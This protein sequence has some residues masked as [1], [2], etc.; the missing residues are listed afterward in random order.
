MGGGIWSG[1]SRPEWANEDLVLKV[2]AGPQ[3]ETHSGPAHDG[4]DVQRGG[5][6]GSDQNGVRP[7]MVDL[8]LGQFRLWSELGR[9]NTRSGAPWIWLRRLH[10]RRVQNVVKR[11]TPHLQGGS[12]VSSGWGDPGGRKGLDT[13]NQEAQGEG[14]KPLPKVRQVGLKAGFVVLL[15]G[16]SSIQ[17]S[18]EMD[19]HSSRL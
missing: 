10:T 1:G 17:F 16:A 5:G 6:T 14:P 9:A 19:R 4:G 7:A 3:W 12:R 11:G 18:P 15:A 8:I 2:G 13:Q